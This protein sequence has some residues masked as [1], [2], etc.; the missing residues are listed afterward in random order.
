MNDQLKTVS[1]ISALVLLIGLVSACGSVKQL[2]NPATSQSQP[3]PSSL[4]GRDALY[5]TAV[6]SDLSV[7][8]NLSTSAMG[9]AKLGLIIKNVGSSELVAVP[10]VRITNA[11]GFVVQPY[12][13]QGFMSMAASMAGTAVP[14]IPSQDAGQTYYSAGTV[15]S[16]SGAT[17]NYSGTTT[18]TANFGSSFAQGFNQGMALAAI[19]R[20]NTGYSMMEWGN[21]YWL[22]S[23]YTLPPGG[24]AAGGIMFPSAQL[25]LPLTIDI[26]V[27]GRRFTFTT[28]QKL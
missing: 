1:R 20:R 11:S 13:H 9:M 4:S 2:N 15:T 26:D 25:R 10:S 12:T 28:V 8:Y 23:Q 19:G 16:N 6:K 7:S 14:P 17:Y 5:E 3:D 27:S 18:S 24:A 21:T 22:K